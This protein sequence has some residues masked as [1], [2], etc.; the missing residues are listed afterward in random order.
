MATRAVVYSRDNESPGQAR[1]QLGVRT[2]LLD[3]FRF[4]H[5]QGCLLSGTRQGSKFA[6]QT[7]FVK[8]RFRFECFLKR[9]VGHPGGIRRRGTCKPGL[10]TAFDRP[11]VDSGKQKRSCDQSQKTVRR[12]PACLADQRP[13]KLGGNQ[14]GKD[15]SLENGVASSKKE[16]RTRPYHLT[17]RALHRTNPIRARSETRS[18]SA[19]PA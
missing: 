19:G 11:R 2:L 7:R 12:A 18:S 15:P 9:A 16:E 8:R 10:R 17:R 1:T 4:P 13:K 5:G 6:V 3:F 14:Q